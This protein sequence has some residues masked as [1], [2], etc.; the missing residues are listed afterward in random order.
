MIRANN[1]NRVK[2]EKFKSRTT[3]TR[4]TEIKYAPLVTEISYQKHRNNGK[5]KKPSNVNFML[6]AYVDPV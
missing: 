1:H 4:N 6:I 3:S 5:Y 2:R